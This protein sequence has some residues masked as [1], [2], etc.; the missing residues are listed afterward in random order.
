M[1]RIMIRCPTHNWPVFTG[2]TTEL[3]KLDSM[4]ETMTLT[5][6]CPACDVDH[7]WKR[8]DA[9]VDEHGREQVSKAD[10]FPRTW[11]KPR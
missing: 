5:V 7:K 9:W 10:S 2:L 3:I 11:R 1:P 4:F 8:E 6:R